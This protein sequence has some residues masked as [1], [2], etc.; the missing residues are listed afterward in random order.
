M[1][2]YILAPIIRKYVKNYRASLVFLAAVIVLAY[3]YK[4]VYSYF[5]N[6]YNVPWAA[7]TAGDCAV[8]NLISFAFGTVAWYAIYA[9]GYHRSCLFPRNEGGYV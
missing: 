8:F 3:G 2:Y 4:A 5:L 9:A 1:L 6:R 7:E